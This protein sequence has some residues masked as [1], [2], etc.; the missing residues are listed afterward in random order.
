MLCTL[1]MLQCLMRCACCI[2]T[3]FSWDLDNSGFVTEKE[4]FAPGALH[5]FVR[6]HLLPKLTDQ[7]DPRC[8]AHTKNGASSETPQLASS[9]ME[10]GYPPA[11]MRQDSGSVGR[12]LRVQV[13]MR[14]VEDSLA[15]PAMCQESLP[16]MRTT[17][18][19]EYYEN[20]L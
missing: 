20:T 13:G 7:T 9:S 18:R 16:T 6:T 11:Q 19:V 15:A 12:Q 17:R 2:A 3:S 10:R 5:D 14:Q 4:F 8:E 1:N